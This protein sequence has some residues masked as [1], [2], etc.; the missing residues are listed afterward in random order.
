MPVFATLALLSCLVQD[1]SDRLGKS[2]AQILSMGRSGWSRFFQKQEGQSSLSLRRAEGVYGAALARRSDRVAPTR[3]AG[4][5]K[6]LQDIKND[7]IAVGAEMTGLEEM[8][9]LTSARLFV[10]AEETVYAVVTESA[11]A[12]PRVVSAVYRSYADLRAAFRR[13]R[14]NTDTAFKSLQ[15]DIDRAIALA[16]HQPR[17]ESD[18]LLEYC[19]RAM[20]TVRIRSA[21]K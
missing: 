18:A 5:R 10:D 14:P 12:P 4:I 13:R 2:E 21:T 17:A 16:K 6:P 3:V 19:I 9:N 8:W 1:K 20:D 7:V 15:Q 11:K